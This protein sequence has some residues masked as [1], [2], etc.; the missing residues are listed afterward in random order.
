[1]S[2]SYLRLLTD[3]ETQLVRYP[4]F[5][6]HH[7]MRPSM[8]L[9]Q[10]LTLSHLTV[11]I[12]SALLIA[13]LT[14]GGY[15]AYT[16]TDSSALWVANAAANFSD[17]LAYWLYE[18][19]AELDAAYADMFVLSQFGYV[20]YDDETGENIEL[21]DR[22]YLLEEW[23]VI[24][25]ADGTILAS[26]YERK[27]P[28]GSLIVDADAPGVDRLWP[29][30]I[31][32]DL[33][34]LDFEFDLQMVDAMTDYVKSAENYVALSPILSDDMSLVGYVYYRGDT[35]Q[36][37]DILSQ[38]AGILGWGLLGA[39]VIAVLLS[40][41]MG[42]RLAR[43]ISRR[44]AR[45]SA[46]SDA[47]A[48]G[49]FSQRVEVDAEDEI[50]RLSAEFNQM[51]GQIE[52]QIEAMRD[53]TRLDERNRLAR[54][55]HDAIKQQLFGLNL[56]VGSVASI[57]DSK[58]DVAIKRLD[59]ASQ[60]TQNILEEMDAIIKQLRP[61]SL[62]DRGLATALT[63]LVAQWQGQTEVPITWNVSGEREL[64]LRIEQGVYRIVQ[65]ALNNIARHAA[66]NQVIMSLEYDLNE[67]R[68]MVTDD[69]KGFDPKKSRSS[70]SHGL[71]NM[72]ERAVELG[73]TL[74]FNS[75]LGKG[76]ALHLRVPVPD[77]FQ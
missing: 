32:D 4:I 36:A 63:D 42:S 15:W 74:K 77:G 14:L 58:P 52:S 64:P 12:V 6:S 19:N 40:G 66:A 27:F 20:N 8:S 72:Q 1:M 68:L 35:T 37:N 33:D 22:D 31:P 23:I 57:V 50:G 7:I 65:E 44:I 46:V 70:S 49:D 67:L 21:T 13:A 3:A 41:V 11:V 51:A 29:L 62:K 9:Q 24:L 75:Q 10:K 26:S 38:T 71:R 55:L 73:G 28:V 25:G 17:E 34:P 39:T 30:D 47:F 59:Q 53:L 43:P 45:L 54:D 69:G 5:M 18:D 60:M 48:A 61:A 2:Q 56:T 16:Q 76:S